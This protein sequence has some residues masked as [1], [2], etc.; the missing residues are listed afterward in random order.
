MKKVILPGLAVVGVVAVALGGVWWIRNREVRYSVEEGREVGR[1]E[2]GVG[3]N[4]RQS[5]DADKKQKELPEWLG[6]YIT[7][8]VVRTKLAGK[9]VPTSVNGRFK[10]FEPIQ[11]SQDRYLVLE[12]PAG[13]T[14]KVRLVF[15]P[16][17]EKGVRHATELSIIRPTHGATSVQ[18]AL[19]VVGDLDQVDQDT[20]EFLFRPGIWV[21]AMIYLDSANRALED[22]N[23][24]YFIRAVS[25][26]EN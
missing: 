23:G 22:E 1:R 3:S 2:L 14:Y 11:N 26:K 15:A 6:N 12:T 7:P 24:V 13:E 8:G 19:K 21:T 5:Q 18:G 4:K 20:R 10:R 17:P 9:E 25:I 16:Q